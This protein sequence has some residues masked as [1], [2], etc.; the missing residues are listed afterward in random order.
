MNHI[1]E[2]QDYAKKKVAAVILQGSIAFGVS[3][4]KGRT[5]ILMTVQPT[6]CQNSTNFYLLPTDLMIAMVNFCDSSNMS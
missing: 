4:G 6:N 3:Q 2:K 5:I 1:L